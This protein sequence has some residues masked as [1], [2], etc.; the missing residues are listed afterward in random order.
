MVYIIELFVDGACRNNGY[1]GAV[2]AAAAVHKLRGN[3]HFYGTEALED[4]W[5]AATNQR[6]EILAI[7]LGLELALDKHQ[8]LRSGTACKV[9]IHSDSK[10]AI[11]CM[12]EW[13]YKWVSNGWI[14]ARGEPVANQD[15][16]KEANSLDDELREVADVTYVWIPRS[17]NSLADRHC[18]EA[19]DDM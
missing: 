14:N 4:R 8:E 9:T 15:L 7:K 5:E 12:R 18:N 16:I 19:L 10:Y 13:V 1:A 6:A 3:N 2:G 17:E 11:G